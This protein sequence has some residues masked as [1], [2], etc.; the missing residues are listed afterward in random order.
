MTN[1]QIILIIAGWV[2]LV[3]AWLRSH[4]PETINLRAISCFVGMIIGFLWWLCSSVSWLSWI[5]PLFGLPL[6]NELWI[7]MIFKG[8]IAGWGGTFGYKVLADI[9]REK[10]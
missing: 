3:V 4:L 5:P 8:F 2:V 10:R 6:I 7:A 9:F 1:M